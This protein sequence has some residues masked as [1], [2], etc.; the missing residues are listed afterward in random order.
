MNEITQ[1]QVKELFDYRNGNLYWKAARSNI[2]AG[3]LAGTLPKDGYRT[4]GINGTRYYAHRLIY[5]FHHAFCH[6]YLDHIDGNPLNSC[7]ENLRG[8][9][10]QENGMNRKKNESMNGKSQSSKFKGVSL[11]N[12]NKKWRAYIGREYLGSFT[13][14]LEAAKA[15]DNAALERD[16][17]FAK[18]NFED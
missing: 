1:D 5:I 9:T 8:A 13:S 10:H 6:P 4:I 2:K 15:Y 17:E 11:F 3:D 14:E 16:G 18:L 7:I 12:R